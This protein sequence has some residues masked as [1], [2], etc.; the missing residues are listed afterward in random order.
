MAKNILIRFKNF[1]FKNK[2]SNFQKYHKY[3]DIHKSSILNNSNLRFDL[4]LSLEDRKYLVVGRECIISG[5]FI[6]ESQKGK[7]EIGNNVHIGSAQFISR[8]KIEIHD[9][10]TAAWDI[11][12]YDHNS[13]SIFWDER[14]EDNSQ[15]Y[16]DF[17]NHN[18]NTVHN[19]N[20]GNVVDK[21]I[22][23]HSKVWIGFG[24]TILKGVTIGEGAVIGAKS[25]IT[26]DVPPWSVVAGNPAKVVKIL[27]KY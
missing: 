5:T 3:L 8:N 20:W 24:V 12:F 6:F 13:H 22:I 1:I 4:P 11:V 17:F 21:P 26:K 27:N 16:K 9:D 23:I 18:G 10:V 14:K 7:I 19:K 25:V 15:C 2:K